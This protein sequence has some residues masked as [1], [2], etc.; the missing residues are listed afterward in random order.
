MILA[1][2]AKGN[3]GV[4]TDILSKV[5][6]DRSFF[7]TLGDFYPADSSVDITKVSIAG[8]TCDWF[9]P[10]NFDENKIII[11]LHGGSF[12]L[13]SMQSHKPM[14]SHFASALLTKILFVEYGLAPEK[15]F[16]NGVNDLLKVYRELIHKFPNAKISII[17]DSAGGGLT[18]SFIHMAFKEKMQMPSS[19]IFISPWIY[20]Q[21]NTESYETRKE[22]DKVLTKDMLTEY[23]KYYA[24]NNRNDADPGQL[25]F[26]S[27]PP[28]FILVGS[29]EILFDDSKNFYE[30][31][32]P[33]QPDTKMKEYKNQSH[34][35]LL[36][37]IKSEASKNALTDIKKF[38]LF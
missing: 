18:V 27:F 15:P 31:I 37:D 23:A 12:A 26:N 10:G 16:P 5:N 19:V 34:V 20:L 24:A 2:E 8:V 29:N 13:G 14:V 4:S 6:A 3:F 28:L 1:T 9:T 11:Y 7:N 33:L 17:A 36:T 32:K 22:A 25:K 21:C 38:I 35:W 30:K